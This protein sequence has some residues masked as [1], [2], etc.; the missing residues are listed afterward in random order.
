MTK[1]RIRHPLRGP[2]V[3]ASRAVEPGVLLTCKFGDGGQVDNSSAPAQ[4]C[5]SRSE[6]AIGRLRIR[7]WI[8]KLGELGSG[9]RQK[10]TGDGVKGTQA[11]R[12]TWDL[13]S[14]TDLRQPKSL[15][16]PVRPT[17]AHSCALPQIPAASTPANGTQPSGVTPAAAYII[18]QSPRGLGPPRG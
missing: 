8:G 13:S 5:D 10:L 11:T 1:P 3:G 9:S 7:R 6:I 2:V 15:S 4:P 14:A 17:S 16:F 18:G 12:A